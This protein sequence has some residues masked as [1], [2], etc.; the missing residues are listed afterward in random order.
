M[1]KL[2]DENRNRGLLTRLILEKSPNR[3]DT[4]TQVGRDG[5]DGWVCDDGEQGD[6]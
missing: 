3:V 2:V 6:Y 1:A 5:Q 4:E